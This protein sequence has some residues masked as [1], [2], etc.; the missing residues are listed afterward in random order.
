MARG[1]DSCLRRHPR[2]AP[3]EALWIRKG[4]IAVNPK[5]KAVMFWVF[6]L[7]CLTLLWSVV[8]KNATM[9]KDTEISYSD[10]FSKVQQ[11]LVLDATIQGNELHGHLKA[12]PR[13]QFHTTLP[14]NDAE[15]EK[16]LL[17]AGVNFSIKEPQGSRLKTLLFNLGPIAILLI[18]FLAAVPPFWVILKKAGFTPWLSLLMLIPVVN[19]VAL[20]IVAFSRW[21][22]VSPPSA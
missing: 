4:G 8:D 13:D 2:A 7:I 1:E 3:F 15:L 9:G 6:V 22:A 19:L 11:G 17:A 5:A 18:V 12:A 20:Y 14:A 10:L 21:K 16:A